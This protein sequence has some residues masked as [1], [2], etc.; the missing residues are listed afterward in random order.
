MFDTKDWYFL[1]RVGTRV[2]LV[3][4][5]RRA[6]KS[7]SRGGGSR[8]WRDKVWWTLEWKNYERVRFLEWISWQYLQ[9]LKDQYGM[10][11]KN[12]KNYTDRTFLNWFDAIGLSFGEEVM[13]NRDCIIH[14]RTNDW[15]IEVKHLG[16]G[17]PCKRRLFQKIHRAKLWCNVM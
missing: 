15:T 5:R 12:E 3:E 8:E 4:A 11:F 6:S 17:N 14:D 9:Q 7:G 10:S 2:N 13:P 16:A 1:V